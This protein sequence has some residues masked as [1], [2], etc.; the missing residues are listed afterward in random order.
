MNIQTQSPLFYPSPVPTHLRPSSA[1]HQSI[2][3]PSHPTRQSAPFSFRAPPSFTNLPA[4]CQ[5]LLLHTCTHLNRLTSNP[6]TDA[7]VI[8][9]RL[10]PTTTLGPNFT[11]PF[12]AQPFWR[13]LQPSH[14]HTFQHP[15]V[16]FPLSAALCFILLPHSSKS[17]ALQHAHS[18]LLWSY[19][20]LH[21][22]V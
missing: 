20:Q 16:T 19:L 1:R 5:V 3:T 10:K 13:L 9:F 17:N 21:P 8:S 22:T 11:I 15:C 2:S 4:I 6:H 18:S 14:T 12:L 7:C